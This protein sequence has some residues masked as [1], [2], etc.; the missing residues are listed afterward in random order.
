[1]TEFDPQALKERLESLRGELPFEITTRQMMGGFVGYADGRVF[2]S[3]SRGGGFG[4]KLLPDDQQRL[5]ERPGA[6]RMQHAADQPASKTYISLSAADLE[7]DDVLLEWVTRA[8][9]TAPGK[10]NRR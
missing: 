8:A 5:L 10:P 9:E 4:V 1:M 3:I 7:D 2:V 6:R